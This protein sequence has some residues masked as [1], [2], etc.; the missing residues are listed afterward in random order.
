MMAAG[1][2]AEVVRLLRARYYG[3]RLKATDR[4]LR[5]ASGHSHDIAR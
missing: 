3:E 5:C 4:S 2:P 1:I